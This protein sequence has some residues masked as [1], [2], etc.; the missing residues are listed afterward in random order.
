MRHGPGKSWP[1]CECRNF[2]EQRF[3]LCQRESLNSAD[4][5]PL[6]WVGTQFVVFGIHEFCIFFRSALFLER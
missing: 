6:V 3:E 4:E 5:S 1:D 2:I